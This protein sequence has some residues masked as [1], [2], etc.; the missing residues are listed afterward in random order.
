MEV[1]LGRYLEKDETDPLNNDISNLSYR[2]C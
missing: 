1:H 2:L